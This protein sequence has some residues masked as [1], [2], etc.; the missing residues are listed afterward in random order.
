[1]YGFIKK[2]I[3]KYRGHDF[4]ILEVYTLSDLIRCSRCNKIKGVSDVK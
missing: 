3:C 4:T 1:M 2:Y